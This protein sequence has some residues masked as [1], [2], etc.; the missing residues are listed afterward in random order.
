MES[1]PDSVNGP[2]TVLFV[3][4][5]LSFIGMLKRTFAGHSDHRIMWFTDP[6][7]AL[8]RFARDPDGIDLVITDYNM[9]R[10]TGNELARCLRVLNPA[11]RIVGTSSNIDQFDLDLLDLIIVKTHKKHV[12]IEAMEKVL[13]K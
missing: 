6:S 1:S 13:V 4:D 8:E 12:L 5:D 10:L 3:D 11:I 9:P 7:V 2:A